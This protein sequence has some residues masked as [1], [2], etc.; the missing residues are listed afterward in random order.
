M[1]ELYPDHI[2]VSVTQPGQYVGGERNAVVK[3]HAGV[4]LTFAL[5]YPDTYTVGMSHLGLQILYAM[6][7]ARGDVAAERAF[8][9]WPDMENEL[10]AAGEPLR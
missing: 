5:A 8:A 9:P 2:L 3:D 7:N 4:K 10:R 1:G 6:L